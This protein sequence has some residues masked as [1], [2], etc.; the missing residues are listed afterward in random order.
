[1]WRSP[2]TVVFPTTLRVSHHKGTL[3]VLRTKITTKIANYVDHAHYPIL[4]CT[5]IFY[6]KLNNN[7]IV[8]GVSGK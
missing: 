3:G 4:Y 5:I 7:Y 6:L 2:F 8:R 1:M